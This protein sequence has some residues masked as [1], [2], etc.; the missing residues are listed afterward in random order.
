MMYRNF[1][2]CLFLASTCGCSDSNNDD[3]FDLSPVDPPA[4]PI[5]PANV[6][7]PEWL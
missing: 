5:Q 7:Q 2:I 1:F 3:G 4:N 6:S